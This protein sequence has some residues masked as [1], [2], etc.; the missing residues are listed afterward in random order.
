MPEDEWWSERVLLMNDAQRTAV[1]TFVQWA[2]GI[3]A[4]DDDEDILRSRA[5]GALRKYW[6]KFVSGSAGAVE[7]TAGLPQPTL[8]EASPEE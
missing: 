7:Q 3:V 5:E 4:D 1:A 6:G 8:S 2:R